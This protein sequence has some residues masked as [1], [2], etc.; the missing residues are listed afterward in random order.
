[1]IEPKMAEKTPRSLTWNQP[2]LT[3]M[4]ASAEYDWKYM[5]SVQAVAR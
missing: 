4:S 2:L 1:M 3:L 5:L